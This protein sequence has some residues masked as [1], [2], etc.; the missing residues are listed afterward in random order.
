MKKFH[1]FLIKFCGFKLE[2]TMI[3]VKNC[4]NCKSS[5]RE[6]T[7][8]IAFRGVVDM[9]VCDHCGEHY[10]TIRFEDQLVKTLD[11]KDL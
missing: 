8:G 7:I 1:K 5:K 6:K 2:H 3:K 9:Y 10:P 11:T 4:P